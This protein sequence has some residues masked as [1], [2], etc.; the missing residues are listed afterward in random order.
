MG[1]NYANATSCPDRFVICN[2]VVHRPPKN[3]SYMHGAWSRPGHDH[4]L[5]RG[6]SAQRARVA[7]RSLKTGWRLII[8]L[9]EKPKTLA[10]SVGRVL[11]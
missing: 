10:K 5:L 9:I 1:I 11:D 4:A 3:C 7:E 8:E 6:P 2:S